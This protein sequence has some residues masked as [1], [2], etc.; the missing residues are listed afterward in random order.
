MEVLPPVVLHAD[1]QA[2]LYLHYDD[3]R[4]EE[5]RECLEADEVEISFNPPEAAH[6]A[7]PGKAVFVFGRHHPQVVARWLEDVGEEVVLDPEVVLPEDLYHPP[8]KQLLSLGEALRE[9]SFDYIARGLSR[10]DLPQ[11]IRMAGDDQLHDGPEGSPVVWAPIHAWR[12]LAQLGDTEAIPGLVALFRRTEDWDEWV[13]EDLPKTLARFGAAAIEPVVGFLA[14]AAHGDWARTAAAKTLS[15]LGEHQPELRLEVIGRLSAQL[16]RFAE[17][18]ETLNAMLVTDLWNLKALE[19]MPVIESAFASG[20]VDEAVVGDL[21]DVQIHF[22]LKTQREH[23]RKPNRV[24]I[25]GDKLRA[26]WKAMGLRLPDADG[27]F[28]ELPQP[29][30]D[31]FEDT[32]ESPIISQPYVA[33][34]KTGRNEPCPCGSG[35][36]YKKCCGK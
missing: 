18:S 2:G 3:A 22:G 27:S 17:Q 30:P 4:A 19:A 32:S 23:P 34:P 14:N 25:L 13:S 21:E 31:L 28:P 20:R 10:N 15:V 12:A 6:L 11:L 33:P 1:E 29:E 7:Q 5:L 16:E 35:K 26:Q 8:V 24:T 9:E 36:K